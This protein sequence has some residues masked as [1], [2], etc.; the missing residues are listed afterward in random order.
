MS[1]SRAFSNA[2]DDIFDRSHMGWDRK[3]IG[4]LSRFCA[5]CVLI[6]RPEEDEDGIPGFVFFEINT[7]RRTEKRDPVSPHGTAPIKEGSACSIREKDRDWQC[8]A[9][10]PAGSFGS[11]NFC[12]HGRGKLTNTETHSILSES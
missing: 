5:G 2:L 1:F 9:K 7:F 11:A 8:G 10:N 4:D 12:G 3:C 6:L